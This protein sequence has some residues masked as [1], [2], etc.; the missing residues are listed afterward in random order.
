MTYYCDSREFST[1]AFASELEKRAQTHNPFNK[2]ATEV[3]S[4]QETS[5][6]I[7]SPVILDPLG[8]GQRIEPFNLSCRRL[9]QPD[10]LECR[11]R[12]PKRNSIKTG[13][14]HGL[15]HSSSPSCGDADVSFLLSP[16]N[17]SGHSEGP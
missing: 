2:I 9:S 14:M 11:E 10:I 6:K 7:E 4:C 8:P 17:S 16:T 5:N 13:S 15:L 1:T 3:P 12:P